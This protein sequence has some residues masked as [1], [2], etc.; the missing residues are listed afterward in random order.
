MN[1]ETWHRQCIKITYSFDKIISPFI[2]KNHLN[3][4]LVPCL[5]WCYFSEPGLVENFTC[6]VFVNFSLKHMRFLSSDSH[7]FQRKPDQISDIHQFQ[8]M[9]STQP[10]PHKLLNMFLR[11]DRNMFQYFF[12]S[13]TDRIWLICNNSHEVFCLW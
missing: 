12:P 1:F 4:L 9:V 11:A 2:F 13:K 5:N 6:C 8:K 7:Q 3:F 10:K